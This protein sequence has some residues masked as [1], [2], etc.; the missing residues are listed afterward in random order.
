MSAWRRRISEARLRGT[1]PRP[2][3]ELRNVSAAYTGADVAKGVDLDVHPGEVV[4]LLGPNGAGKT[5]VLSTIS[6][7]VTVTGGSILVDGEPIHGLSPE[8]IV[9]KGVVHV[10]QGRRLFP[11]STGRENLMAGGYLRRDRRNLRRDVV[12]FASRWTVA[13]RVLERQAMLMS[14]GEQQVVAL[15]RALM[16]R[17][18]VLLLDEPSLGLA[19]ILVDQLF[20]I[21]GSL[22]EEL[23]EQGLGILLVEQNAGKALAIADRVYII[24][25]GRVVHEARAEDIAVHDI[26]TF[27]FQTG[28]SLEGETA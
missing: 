10:P 19:P 26:S 23:S 24:V 28:R 4:A 2:R 1:L 18:Q 5:T 14:G 8:K 11:H 9:G 6:G 17:P 22:A 25:D 12:E 20:E 27:Y 7:L 15:G 16:G 13:E 3:L 21:L